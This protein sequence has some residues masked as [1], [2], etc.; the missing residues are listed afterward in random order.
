MVPTLT[1]FARASLL[2]GRARYQYLATRAISTSRILSSANSD[3]E[4]SQL[5]TPVLL[6]KQFRAK[7]AS[8]NE[9]ALVG[10]G[11]NRIAKQHEKGKLTARERILLLVDEGSFK[12]YDQLKAHRCTD[13]GMEK[14]N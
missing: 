13:F 4:S 9:Q 5:I 2:G 12:E 14:E 11:K 7:L 1:S 10:G 3:S 8:A 6:K